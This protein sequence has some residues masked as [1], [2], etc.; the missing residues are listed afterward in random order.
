MVDDAKTDETRAKRVARV[1]EIVSERMS[2]SEL[3]KASMKGKS[4]R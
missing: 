3:V 2:F 1:L 4:K